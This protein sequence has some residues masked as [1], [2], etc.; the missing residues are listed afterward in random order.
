MNGSK[1]DNKVLKHDKTTHPNENV[2]H[3][4]DKA[5]KN[6]GNKTDRH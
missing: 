4:N 6:K 3:H 1:P 2:A 5:N